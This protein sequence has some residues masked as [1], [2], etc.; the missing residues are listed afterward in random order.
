MSYR[1]LTALVWLPQTHFTLPK[2][3]PRPGSSVTPEFAH[4]RSH[5]QC[6]DAFQTLSAGLRQRPRVLWP[7]ADRLFQLTR[8][9][10]KNTSLTCGWFAPVNS[11][12]SCSGP[13]DGGAW[14]QLPQHSSP[15]SHWTP[16][17]TPRTPSSPAPPLAA[18]PK[19]PTHPLCTTTITTTHHTQSYGQGWPPGPA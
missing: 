6:P 14:H 18:S 5:C 3:T 12:P 9:V 19:P 11:N 8:W 1:I 16:S 4:D 2:P 13:S 15:S 7:S 10:L 17:A